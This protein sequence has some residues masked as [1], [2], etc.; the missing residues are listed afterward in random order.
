[1]EKAATIALLANVPRD[2]GEAKAKAA[3]LARMVKECR[4]CLGEDEMSALIA[5]IAGEA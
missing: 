4:G 3:W 1:V 2:P 5:T